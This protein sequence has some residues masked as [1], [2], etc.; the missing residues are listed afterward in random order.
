VDGIAPSTGCA[1]PG[2]IKKRALVPYEADYFFYK[3]RAFNEPRED[4]D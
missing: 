2:D 4:E 1:G 3:E